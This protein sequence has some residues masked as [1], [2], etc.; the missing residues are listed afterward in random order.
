MAKEN[1]NQT[2]KDMEGAESLDSKGKQKSFVR[3]FARFGEKTSMQGVPYI[4][5]A[6]FWWAKAIWS[7]LL[8]CAVAAMG[9]HLWFLF[10]QWYSW[11]KTTKVELGFET[12]DFPQVT[13]CNTNI[14]HKTRFEKF[15][16][17]DKLKKIVDILRPEN[18]VSDQFDENYTYATETTPEATT[19]GATTPSGQNEEGTDVSCYSCFFILLC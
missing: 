3:L 1:S 10:D 5:L 12:L 6:K 16:G 15:E 2:N 8:L 19:A 14:M 7:F 9:L 13:I 18:L 4:Y 17:A 11:P